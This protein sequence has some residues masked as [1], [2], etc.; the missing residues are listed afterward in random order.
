MEKQITPIFLISLPRSGSTL[1]QKLLMSH[2][3][4]TSIAEP[5]ILL[6]FIYASRESG[7]I[8]EY[9]HLASVRAIL[10]L[11]DLIPGKRKEYFRLLGDFTLK[12]YQSI[13]DS[14]SVYFLDKTPR[15]FWVVRELKEIFPK[16]KFIFLFR[17]P[18]QIY[19]SFIESY[20]DKKGFD[21]MYRSEQY[22]DKGYE[23]LSLG[24]EKVKNDSLAVNYEKL[25][26]NPTSELI[27]IFEYLDLDFDSSIIENFSSQDL[28]GRS[29][30]HTGSKKYNSIVS[31]PLE[32]WKLIFNTNFRKKHLFKS[33]NKIN[34]NLIAIQ[35]YNKKDLLLEIKNLDTDGNYNFVVDSIDLAKNQLIKKFHLNLFFDSK[36]KWAQNSYLN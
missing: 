13:S 33:I 35:G 16:A 19:S 8:A 9:S 14:N 20:S 6:P 10:D 18:I 15:Y 5:H 17:N 23:I 3:R 29:L 22:F 27:R 2:Y 30:D 11:I 31:S 34:S 25:V 32:K 28:K 1:V 7:T 24:Y 4:I 21:K 26:L 12:I 36:M